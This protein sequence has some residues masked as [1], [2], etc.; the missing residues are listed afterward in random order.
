M[1]KS[2]YQVVEVTDLR[3]KAKSYKLYERGAARP[4]MIGIV[5]RKEAE[6]MMYELEMK[7]AA[8]ANG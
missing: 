8:K 4:L 3:T 6:D 2:R 1:P 5:T 7:D